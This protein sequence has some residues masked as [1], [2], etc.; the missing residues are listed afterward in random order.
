MNSSELAMNLDQRTKADGAHVI[1][2]TAINADIVSAF[3]DRI[4]QHAAQIVCPVTIQPSGNF[5]Y[6]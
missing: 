6:Q 2:F 4:E 1:D 3:A 5:Y